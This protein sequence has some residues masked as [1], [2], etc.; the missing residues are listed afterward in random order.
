QFDPSL[1]GLNLVE[2]AKQKLGTSS[3]DDQITLIFEIHGHGGAS[4]VFHGISE[5][6]L[7][8]FLRHPNTMFAS[9]SS[10]RKFQEGVPHPRGY[11]NNA[12]VLARYVRELKLLRLE[13]AVRRM[14]SLP[15]TVFRLPDRGVIRQGACADLAIF[16]PS[17]VQDNATFDKPHQYAT[18]FAWV[19]V[20]GVSVVKQDAHTGARPGRTL[21]HGL[22]K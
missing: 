7:Q 15:A 11:G 2:A 13:D 18:G 1:N 17:T 5:D 16:D 3:L 20:N 14:T 10:V 12:R 21:P 6:D 9:D 8:Q 19:L 4:G 22:T